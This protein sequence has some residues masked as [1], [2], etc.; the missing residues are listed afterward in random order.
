MSQSEADDLFRG[1]LESAP[2]AILGLNEGVI[3]FVNTQTERLFGYRREELLNQSVEML[4]RDTHVAHRAGY[5]AD[6]HTRPS[7]P[8]SA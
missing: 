5:S 1:L 2:D 8:R 3:V 4:L 6:P 7:Q